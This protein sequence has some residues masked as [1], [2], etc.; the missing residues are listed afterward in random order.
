MA[1]ASFSGLAEKP[2]TLSEA[3]IK[4]FWEDGFL[5]I[6]DV[7]TRE[8][9]EELRAACD[10]PAVANL[11]KAAGQEK[12]TV[13]LLE[14]TAKHPALLDLATDH[15]IVH[16]LTGLIGPDIQLQHSK[17]AAQAASKGKGGFHWH[18][19]FAFFP[20]TNTDLVAVMVLLDDATLQN[21]CMNMVRGSHKLG[22]LNHMQDG[23]F[24][25]SCQEAR[26]WQEHPENVTPITP[27]AGGISL[28]HCLTLHGSGP[29]LSGR[30]RR[31]I[32]FQYRADD[33]YQLA[34]AVWED[35]GL[36]V[37]GQRRERVRCDAGSLRLPR[38]NRYPGHPF[39]NAWNQEGPLARQANGGS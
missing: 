20:H 8:E 7:F 38:S 21:G 32:V 37:C 16:R 23:R 18:Q 24:T 19:D 39:G 5:V 33:A 36:M 10:S 17:L 26:V 4:Q 2:V 14:I 9:V 31:G 25:G 29:N 22:L 1:D 6:N 13:H 11:T 34:D 28:H 12:Q 3:D 30:P 27:R 35:T 15:R